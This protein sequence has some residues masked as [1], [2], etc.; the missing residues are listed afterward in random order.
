[1]RDA[2]H[3]VEEVGQAAERMLAIYLERHPEPRGKDRR[4]LLEVLMEN[5]ICDRE[6]IERGTDDLSY[7]N[8]RKKIRV[9]LQRAD[10]LGY[11]VAPLL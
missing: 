2:P 8:A 11:S 5:F 3:F 10:K 9:R 4:F 1:M 6:T 7:R